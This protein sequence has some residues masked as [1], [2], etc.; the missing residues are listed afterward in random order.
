VTQTRRAARITFCSALMLGAVALSAQGPLPG[1]VSPVPQIQPQTPPAATAAAQPA[2]PRVTITVGRSTVLTLD[3]D[4][5]RVIVTDPE[6]ANPTPI[7]QRQLLIDGKKPGT[8]SLII[9]RNDTTFVQYDL[10]VDPGVTALQ[11]QLQNVFPGEDIQAS[12]TA[13]AVILTGHASNNN[14]MLKAGDLAAALAPKAKILNLLQLPGGSG[15]QQVMLQVRIAEVNR[16][17]VYELG[18]AFFT[19]ATGYKD[20]ITRGTTQQFPAPDFDN[21]KRVAENGQ[22]TELTGDITFTD[23]LNLFIFNTKFNVGTLIK[24]L[25]TTG[26]FQSLAEPNLIAYNGVKASFLAGGE[27]PIPVVQGNTGGVT[28][29][30]KEFGIKL[31]FTP[32]IAG[33]VIRL[34]VTPEVSSLDFA[35]GITLGGFRVPAITTR[36]AQTEVELRDGQSFAIGGL[37]QNVS[38][39]TRQRV[40]GLANL[41]LIGRFFQSKA[42]SKEQTELLVLV[43]P[44]LVKALNP[45]QVPP[46]PTVPGKFLPPCDK[47][48]CDGQTPPA[49]GTGRGGGGGGGLWPSR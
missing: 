24:A 43:T 36:R 33:D 31:E 20:I 18:A 8:T 10:V 40:P 1:P 39:E 14:V 25:Q 37:M 15:S 47:P 5:T 22:V 32:T 13:D 17:A 38:Q 23:F 11:R 21:L 2:L 35:N 29:Q 41:P 46:L 4:V 3:F 26:N 16:R 27:L 30:F 12:E 34:Q 7:D 42:T 45:D 49:T 6:I 28:L 9:F 48:P 44:H 19:G